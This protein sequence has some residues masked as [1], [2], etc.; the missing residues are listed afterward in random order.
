MAKHACMCSQLACMNSKRPYVGVSWCEREGCWSSHIWTTCAP[1][2][3]A[4]LILSPAWLMLCQPTSMP[5]AAPTA[6]VP[7]LHAAAWRAWPMCQTI[8]L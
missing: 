4:C 7:V 1:N 8:V 3:T 6:T 2:L 5:Y